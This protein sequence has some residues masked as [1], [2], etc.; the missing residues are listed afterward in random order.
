MGIVAKHFLR[1][2]SEKHTRFQDRCVDIF[3]ISDEINLVDYY[4]CNELSKKIKADVYWYNSGDKA[5]VCV[6]QENVDEA[7]K[8]GKQIIIKNFNC[9]SA[10]YISKGVLPVLDEYSVIAAFETENIDGLKNWCK[11]IDPE[12]IVKINTNGEKCVLTY[13]PLEFTSRIKQAHTNDPFPK[14]LNFDFIKI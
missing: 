11:L 3:L 4:L 5:V 8:F 6:M 9:M 13:E 1:D 7:I 14:L 10:M 12:L 2:S